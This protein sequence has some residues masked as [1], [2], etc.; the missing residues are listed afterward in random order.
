MHHKPLILRAALSTLAGFAAAL[1]FSCEVGPNYQRPALDVPATFKSDAPTTTQAASHPA[2]APA[3]QVSAEWW[4]LFNDDQLTTLETTAIHSNQNLRAAVA[5]V[6][7]ARAAARI[8]KS[9][10]FPTVTSTPS[11]TRSRSSANAVQGENSNGGPITVNG[12][13]VQSSNRR[14][15]SEF[16]LPGGT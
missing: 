9:A 10:F 4:R 11:F 16:E 14:T 5:R 2:T 3:T 12:N 1:L 6:L 15:S 7:E 8:T 13:T